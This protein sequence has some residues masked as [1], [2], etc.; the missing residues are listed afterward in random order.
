M[1]KPAFN[2]VKKHLATEAVGKDGLKRANSIVFVSDR[3]QARITALDFVTF[4][5]CEENPDLFKNDALIGSNEKTMISRFSEISTKRCLEHGIGIVHE[6]LTKAEVALMKKL[7]K[8]GAI[9]VLVVTQNFS[10]ELIGLSTN[11]V[12]LMDVERYDGAEG[13]MVEYPMADVLQ[14]EGLASRTLTTADGQRLAPKCLLM[15]YTPRRDYFI[16]FL[17]EPLPVESNLAENL[18]DALNAEIVVGTIET[19]QDA[20]DWMTWTF[21]YRRLAP[22][23][24]YYNLSGRSAQHINDFLS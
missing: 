7:F 11:M 16:K 20:V 22:N 9:K 13:R 21:L 8:E 4:A 18:H 23:P 6:G 17:Q 15:C 10:W 1:A 14:M 3:K 12:V 2:H 24:N 19:K 5:T